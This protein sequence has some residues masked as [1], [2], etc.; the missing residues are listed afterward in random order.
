MSENSGSSQSGSFVS[1]KVWVVRCPPG[2][3]S[4]VVKVRRRRGGTVTVRLIRSVANGCFEWERVTQAAPACERWNADAVNE[5]VNCGKSWAAHSGG[6]KAVCAGWTVDALWVR[7]TELAEELKREREGRQSDVRLAAEEARR[8]TRQQ[9]ADERAGR[10]CAEPQ[11]PSLYCDQ[12]IWIPGQPPLMR[13][14]APRGH[15]GPCDGR[16]EN[17]GQ[18]NSVKFVYERY[19]EV[20]KRLK[21]RD[22][23]L[24]KVGERDRAID[25]DLARSMDEAR[26][27]RAALE[28]AELANVDAA[29]RALA[30]GRV[31]C[32]EC[33]CEEGA[34]AKPARRCLVPILPGSGARCNGA[35]GPDGVCISAYHHRPCPEDGCGGEVLDGGKCS[36]S[37]WHSFGIR[38]RGLPRTCGARVL[39]WRR[40]RYCQAL[41]GLD[42]YCLSDYRHCRP[43]DS[44]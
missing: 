19:N 12:W 43:G 26:T 37:D 40:D 33:S 11:A 23:E 20:R 29:R 24:A 27:L 7:L 18:I 15:G 8:E 41:V 3:V 2:K 44:A 16:A 30:C 22:A 21:S 31:K 14:V 5:C 25:E 36:V 42:G 13:C 1:A 32:G 35:V 4:D 10:A 6:T 39:G 9:L 38:S 34:P 17:R 28:D